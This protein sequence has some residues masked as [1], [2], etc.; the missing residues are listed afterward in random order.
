MLEQARPRSN[1]ERI[2]SLNRRYCQ[3]IVK[4]G[5]RVTLAL[6]HRLNQSLKYSWCLR[7]SFRDLCVVSTRPNFVTPFSFSL[8]PVDS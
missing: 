3:G 5:V 2:N 1:P 8:S 6:I 7:V 4:Q